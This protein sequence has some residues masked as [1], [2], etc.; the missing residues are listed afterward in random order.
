[1]QTLYTL[2][3]SKQ[4][5]RKSPPSRG[6]RKDI[7]IGRGDKVERYKDQQYKGDRLS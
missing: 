5:L 6:Q 2:R 7:Q 1:M 4:G 3:F